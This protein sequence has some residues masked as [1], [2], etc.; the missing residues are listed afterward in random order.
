MK[1]LISKG[2]DDNRIR[3]FIVEKG[4]NS[5]STITPHYSKRKL[6]LNPLEFEDAVS[7]ILKVKPPAKGKST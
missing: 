3:A 5:L 6:S 4:D 1:E 2:M 7:D